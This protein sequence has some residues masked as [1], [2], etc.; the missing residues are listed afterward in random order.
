MREQ[1]PD[2]IEDPSDDDEEGKSSDDC[3]PVEDGKAPDRYG[4]T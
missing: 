3:G 4:V 1:Y 2:E